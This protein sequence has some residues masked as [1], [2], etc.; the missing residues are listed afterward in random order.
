MGPFFVRVLVSV[1]LFSCCLSFL[2]CS[3]LQV[4]F[5]VVCLS[6]VVSVWVLVFGL[7]FLLLC[8]GIA[9]CGG[10]LLVV[11]FGFSC[12]LWVCCYC[13]VLFRAAGVV[14][15]LFVLL[16]SVV[17]SVLLVVSVC[18]FLSVVS[19]VVYSLSV[20]CWAVFFPWSAVASTTG[21]SASVAGGWS[22][23]VKVAPISFFAVS[24]FV[25]AADRL[26]FFVGVGF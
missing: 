10:G 17:C 4:V 6:L 22:W 8:F 26:F 18:I 15:F 20:V 1:L 19:I 12:C 3:C 11:V 25:E 2:V 7:C 5:G 23:V 9:C 14:L 21:A 24:S 16:V 13:V